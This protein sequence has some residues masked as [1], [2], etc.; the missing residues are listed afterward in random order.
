MFKLSG[1]WHSVKNVLYFEDIFT[2]KKIKTNKQITYYNDV[3]AFDIE[4]SSFKDFDFDDIS[5]RDEEVY[6]YLTG[7]KIKITQSF[8]N[9]IPDLA[10][11]RRELFGRLYF[12]RT[13][14]VAVDKLYMELCNS[15]PYWFSED[16]I[17]PCDQL[18]R[19]LTVFYQNMP[20]NKDDFADK[21]AIMY[22]WQ[23]AIN[24]TVIIGRTWEEFIDL[25]NSICDYFMLNDK[26]RMICYVHSLGYEFQFIKG[27]F[28]WSK[29]FAASTRKPIYALT[30]RGFEFRCSYI[31]SGMSLAALGKTLTKYKV[32]KM[33]GDLD[34]SLIRHSET[35]LT[36]EDTNVITPGTE[37][38]Y[39]CNDVLV[40]SAYIKEQMEQE[41]DDITKL[42]LTATG[43]CRR[44]VRKNCLGGSSRSERSENFKEY[45][46][47]MRRLT[48]SGF[49]EFNMMRRAYTGGFTH[50]NARHVG[51]IM[52][53]VDSFDF[54]SSYPYCLCSEKYPMS[55]GTKVNITSYKELKRY[56][57][58][59]CC[60]FDA[61]FKN[62]RPKYTNENYLSASKC[63]E[64]VNPVLN[65]G[66]VVGADT[67]AVTITEIDLQIIEKFYCYESMSIGEC[68]VYKKDYLPRP[69]IMSVLTSYSNKTKL[70][71]VKGQ[72]A[73]Y[74]KMKGPLLNS[75]YGMM[76]TCPIMPLHEYDD[77]FGWNVKHPDPEKE[78]KKY[79]KS[80]KRFLFYP[81]GLWCVKYAT[82][83]LILGGIL[84]AGDDY[85]Y[86][87]TDSIKILNGAKH[88]GH[89]D[90][91]NRMVERK[92]RLVSEHYDI[93]FEMFAPRTVKG[94]VKLLGV[95][96]KETN[97]PWS[98]FKTLGAKR[99]LLMESD[100]EMSLTV[101]GVNKKAA[102]PY[103]ID[104]YGKEG[105]FKAFTDNLIIPGDHTGKMTHYYLDDPYQGEV[106]DYLGNTIKY[107]AKSG[108][109]MEPAS[110]SFSMEESYLNYLRKIQ[111][112]LI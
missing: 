10:G 81:W 29:V 31:L 91:Y 88:Q 52:H 45:S 67:L 77:T 96:D 70:K 1:E 17:N 34:Y 65:N 47:L 89:I 90:K 104:K 60:M 3:L 85:I 32:E 2:Y 112:V 14:G 9:D 68:Y 97:K 103:L 19:I 22:V 23:M 80:K 64:L 25:V 28:K 12:S 56:C 69:V 94:E 62:I 21:R 66:R 18:E 102:L 8:Y 100:G 44:Y 71:G 54:T 87:D 58:L 61:R 16:I 57:R 26:K 15:F 20:D 46:R 99:Y 75:I 74:Q 83:N 86:S 40:V 109:Y 98:S 50:G 72:E 6:H 82:R 43:I 55:R 7:T 84:P 76:V 39:C 107:K 49:H 59:Y 5:A 37:I 13:E 4:T 105:T 24:G 79:N 27:Y 95:W 35:P 53:D 92:L 11:I 51:K 111:G 33:S 108:I 48:I 78:I 41:G 30:D 101:S 63:W 106:T 73:L 36:G 38:G 42:T 110:Y 93:P